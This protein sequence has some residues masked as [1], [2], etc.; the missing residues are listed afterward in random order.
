MEYRKNPPE[1]TLPPPEAGANPALEYTPLPPEFGQ[2][3]G[4]A[5]ETLRKKRRLRQLLAVP[6]VL[7][8]GFLFLHGTKPQPDIPIPTEP[9]EDTAPETPPVETA[10]EAPALPEGSVVFDVLYAVRDGD[11]VRYSYEVHDATLGP[12][13]YDYPNTPWP[14]S[15]YAQVSDGAGQGVSPEGDPD[16]WD[17]ERDWEEHVINAEGLSGELTLTLRAEYEQDG[18]MRQTVYTK[19][20]EALPPAP[21]FTASLEAVSGRKDEINYTAVLQPQPGDDHDYQL[22]VWFMGQHVHD[23]EEIM[24]FSL[25]EDPRTLPVEGNN[26]DGY[27]VRYTGGSA[28]SFLP[29]GLELTVY[30]G[31]RDAATGY[32]YY[33]ESNP[34]I[35]QPAET[36]PTYPLEDGKIS[37]TVYN[38]T[39]TFDV[40]SPVGNDDYLTILDTNA[41]PEAEFTEY[42]LPDPIAPKGYDFVGWV[43]HV[44]NPFD[45]STD[46]NV[47]GDYNGDP[48]VDVLINES[49]YAF[50][51]GDVLTRED[52]EKVPP[53]EDGVRW[54]NVHAVWI[55]RNPED[56]RLYLDDG[57][58]N[59]TEYGMDSPMASEGYL[60]L[61]SYP[62]SERD[63]LV[64]DGWYDENGERVDLLVSFFS[65][66]PVIY[67]SNGS[68]QGY[69]WSSS[70]TVH[71][72]ARW[73]PA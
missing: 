46:A 21:S 4:P 20:L 64:F 31:L 70:Q 44:N 56:I 3:S 25:G 36:L 51:V 16:V 24:G 23:G 7:L 17:I 13:G 26:Q 65:F 73:R 50:P 69:D 47:F 29:E 62:V 42:A 34:I 35:T 38:D 48:P 39:M 52:L 32:V 54:V 37:L 22:S 68:F 55:A 59:V 33:V 11:L 63:G 14:I 58:G 10:T 57:I 5:G 12:N 61:C 19:Q 30:L 45:L 8:L 6:A 43:I 72:T 60:Y 66:T 40:P 9:V 67:D 18:E 41:F 28:L 71:L 53:D 27:T 15:V 49:N 1:L 2:G